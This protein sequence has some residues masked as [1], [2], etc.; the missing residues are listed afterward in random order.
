MKNQ[1]FEILVVSKKWMSIIIFSAFMLEIIIFPTFTNFLG[2]LLA[3]FSWFIFLFF[4]KKKI[5]LNYPFA[6]LMY[7][8]MFLYRFLPLIATIVEGRPV[9]F[10]FENSIE[11]ILYEFILFGVSS[12]AFYWACP[13]KMRSTNYTL[14]KI[15][16]FYKF[17]IINSKT[18]WILGIL[19]LIIRI[20][21]FNA[22]DIEFGDVSGKFLLGLNYL[23]YSPVL[24]FFPSLVGLNK[25]GSKFYLWSYLGLIT[26]INIASN[27]RLSIITPIGTYMLLFALDAIINKVDVTQ[28]LSPFRIIMITLFI[29]F[30]LNF[31][32]DISTAILYTR[33]FRADISKEQI[34]LQTLEVYNDK[35]LMNSLKK[36]SKA[37]VLQSNTYSDGWDE[38]YID[39]FML[40]RYANLRIS[41][42]SLHYAKKKGFNNNEMSIFFYDQTLALIPG[43]I[44]NFFGVDLDKRNLNF[45]SGDL[46]YGQEG[47]LGTYRVSSHV[48]IGLATFGFSYFPFQLIISFLVFK[49]LNTFVWRSKK[50]IVYAPFAL[51]NVFTFLGMFR[52]SNGLIMDVGYV[53]RGYVQGVFTFIFAFLIASFVGSLI[54]K[55]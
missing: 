54:K 14:S 4:L 33:N 22:G 30:G 21:T 10:G 26:L 45:S 13:F 44:L 23:V 24:L 31:F 35:S 27:S 51:I 29:F 46:L 47:G 1:N 3:V 50:K 40:N 49:L 2:G 16:Y 43:P 42:Q 37:K 15:L 5:I 48:G 34:L 20:Y 6:F 53:L 8:S 18:L 39:N 17:F 9:T 32:S 12:L 36:F 38:S 52:N 28:F 25:R 7:S 19:G 11:T 41:D 55:I